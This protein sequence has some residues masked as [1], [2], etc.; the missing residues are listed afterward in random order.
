MRPS[1]YVRTLAGGLVA[2]FATAGLS[3][4]YSR[5]PEPLKSRQDIA[6]ASAK[7]DNI[8]IA[9]LPLND[10]PALAKFTN[11]KRVR[12]YTR[13]GT[14][15][16]DRKLLAFSRLGFPNLYD[17]TL[18]NCPRVTDRGIEHLAQLP[19]LRYLQ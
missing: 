6:R 11:L 7:T 1:S 4:D 5:Y 10:Y 8:F 16:D 12:F 3:A 19:A 14:G 18:L 9:E 13:A 17:V 2:V 15:S